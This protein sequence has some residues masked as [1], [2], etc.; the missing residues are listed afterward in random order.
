MV[1]SA[2]TLKRFEVEGRKD[3]AMLGSRRRAE[4]G[5]GWYCEQLKPELHNQLTVVCVAELSSPVDRSVGE[6]R[7]PAARDDNK[8]NCFTGH[9]VR[10][11][12]RPVVDMFSGEPGIS[13]AEI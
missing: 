11:L 3:E 6:E 8:V 13:N 10:A 2:S 9:A 4:S 12:R 1:S 7:L 5:R